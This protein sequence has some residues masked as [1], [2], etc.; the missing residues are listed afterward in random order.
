MLRGVRGC[1]G[2]R[3]ARGDEGDR[4]IKMIVSLCRADKAHEDRA[5][6]GTR[7]A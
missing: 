2:G 1:C 6:A 4:V 5:G 7:G 3:C